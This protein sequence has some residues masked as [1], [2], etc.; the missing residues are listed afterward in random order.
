MIAY[1][2]VDEMWQDT[3]ARILTAG[4]ELV[5][6]NGEPTREI[7]GYAAQLLDPEL[8][9]V[10]NPVRRLSASYASA[11][12]LWYMSGSSSGEMIKRY[13][14]SYE[15]FLDD[16]GEAYGAYGPRIMSQ[17]ENVVKTLR[18][19]PH[20]RQAV[21]SIW[22]PSVLERASTE[23][24]TPDVPCTISLQYLLRDG[25]LYAVTSMRSNDCWL[26]LPYD[27]FAF[28]CLQRVI[29]AHL[30]VA[31][32][33]YTHFVGSMHL[34]ARDY[35]RARLAAESQTRTSPHEWALDDTVCSCKIGCEVEH[36]VRITGHLDESRLAACGDMV[37]DMVRCCAM[38]LRPRNH[39]E[40]P[41]SPALRHARV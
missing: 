38:K 8:N 24:S 12:F 9:F 37:T 10:A 7:V 13:A 25:M 1:C 23:N 39:Y 16:D 41:R 27:V 33:H 6:R 22:E 14:P 35:K 11:E 19:A 28:T 30:D 21:I 36:G 40:T 18:N 17:V 3:L 4:R 2:D 32:G 20:S 15:S 26:G 34:Y 5:G 29:A 31:L